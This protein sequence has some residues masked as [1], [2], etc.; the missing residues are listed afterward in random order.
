MPRGCAAE[1]KVELLKGLVQEL[2]EVGTSLAPSP[3]SPGGGKGIWRRPCP[4]V[5]NGMG[6]RQD[7]APAEDLQARSGGRRTEGKSG[8]TAGSRCDRTF[9]FSPAEIAVHRN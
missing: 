7:G 9:T 1:R 3:G 2:R 8:E 5:A 6:R 4:G